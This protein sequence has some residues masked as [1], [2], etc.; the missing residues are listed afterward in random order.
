MDRPEFTVTGKRMCLCSAKLRWAVVGDT[1]TEAFCSDP[2]VTSQACFQEL[3]VPGYILHGI[4]L[5]AISYSYGASESPVLCQLL[6]HVRLFVTPWTIAHQ[7]SLSMG[8]SRQEYW[9]GL[10]FPPSGDHPD[11]GIDPGS[12]ALQKDSLL[13]E[14]HWRS[15]QNAVPRAQQTHTIRRQRWDWRGA[16]MVTKEVVMACT[17]RASVLQ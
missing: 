5:T 8:F 15:R 4:L 10:P 1:G 11:P 17:A 6:S 14:N 12:P 2:L 9:S 13:S 7:A 3:G 16:N